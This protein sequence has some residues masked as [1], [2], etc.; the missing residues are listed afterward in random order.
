M[1]LAVVL[2]AACGPATVRAEDP[3]V[4][5]ATKADGLYAVFETSMGTI[6]C[7]LHY[8]KVPVTVANFVGLATGEMEWKDPKTG[9]M[10]KRPFYDGLKFHR[11]IK[12][13]MIQG[14]CPLGNGRGDPGYKFTDEFDASLRHDGPGVLSMANSGPNTN[15]SQFFI[16]HVATPWL[17]DKH[18]VFGRVVLGQEIVNQ[19]GE[20]PMKGPGTQPSIPVKDIFLTKLSIVRTGAAAQAFDW[21]AAWAK[22]DAAGAKLSAAREKA[23]LDGL[24]AVC[25]QLGVDVS[26]SVKTP[27]GLRYIVKQ[28]GKGDKPKSGKSIS[29]HYTGYLTDGTK[30]DSSRDRGTP[31]QTPIGIGRVIKGWD[32]AFLDMKVGEK[33]VL[34]IPPE[35]GYGSQGT[36]GGPIPPNATLVFDVELVSVAK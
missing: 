9:T 33:R 36:P 23:A 21:N 32:E 3:A 27:S 5:E 12:E 29:A 18:S 10:V 2:L 20:V 11:C 16:T 35:L 15:G 24:G 17:D 4:K 6:V 8:D 28:E 19:M 22:R 7:K 25:T 34:I 13:F 26:K 1:L 30:F 14:G 31:F